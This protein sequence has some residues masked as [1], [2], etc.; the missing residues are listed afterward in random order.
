[1]S[2]QASSTCAGTADCTMM[3][4]RAILDADEDASRAR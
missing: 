1:V 3:E 2:I 4:Q